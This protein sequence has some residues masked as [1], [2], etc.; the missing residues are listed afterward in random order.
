MSNIKKRDGGKSLNSFDLN[1]SLSE[2]APTEMKQGE[3]D[4]LVII[5]DASSSMNEHMQGGKSK[6]HASYN[7]LERHAEVFPRGVPSRK[8]GFIGQT[9]RRLRYSVEKFGLSDMEIVCGKRRV[10]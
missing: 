10:I 5:A 1:M 8:L 6:I 4:S 7:R 3:W 2:L 9:Y